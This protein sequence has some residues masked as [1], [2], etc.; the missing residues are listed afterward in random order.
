[1]VVVIPDPIIFLHLQK[2]GGTSLR[3]VLRDVFGGVRKVRG[4]SGR[5]KDGTWKLINGEL[6]E[7]NAW[8]DHMSFGLHRLLQKP[9]LYFTIVRDPIVREISRFCHSTWERDRGNT[10]LSSYRPHWGMVYQLSGVSWNRLPDLTE[11]HVK[12]A[13][14]N[15]KDHFLYVGD[16]SRFH[17]V[18][19]WMRDEM[20]WP[21]ELP[22]P[23]V[24]KANPDAWVTEKEIEELKTHHLV[25]LDQM[26]YARICEL[27]PYPQKWI[28]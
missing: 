10:P 16:T 9:V 7:A 28:L 21:V 6:L 11:V 5:E 22:L 13:L 3:T 23:H 25:Q 19:L 4:V 27:G 8:H 1:V 18:G 2:T 14:R 20:G 26:L 17:K 15:M 24:N 12:Q